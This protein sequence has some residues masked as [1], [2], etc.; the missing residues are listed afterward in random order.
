VSGWTWA[1][2]AL[3]VALVEVLA[4]GFYLVWIALGGLVTGIAVLLFDVQSLTTQLEIFAVAVV[5]SCIGGFFVYRAIADTTAQ[6]L[7]NR[8]EAELIGARGVVAEP[9]TNGRG[10]IR[11]G[12]TVWLAEG[13]DL[14]AGTPVVVTKLRGTVAVVAA[15]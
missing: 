1:T 3:L 4:P 11:L 2:A 14:P 7:V 12:D 15:A 9:L 5:A 8:R 13:P 6:Q 10:K